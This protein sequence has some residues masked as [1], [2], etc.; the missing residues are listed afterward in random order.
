MTRRALAAALEEARRTGK[1]I[2]AAVGKRLFAPPPPS[3]HAE[4]AALF[5]HIRL[6]EAQYPILKDVYA[7]PNAEQSK[8]QA[9]KKWAEGMRPGPPDINVD[10]PN[11]PYHGLRIEFKRP[12]TAHRPSA[13]SPE[14]RDWIAR[15]HQGRDAARSSRRARSCRRPRRTHAA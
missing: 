5:K 10:V 8:A 14:Q 2:P 12:G 3:E 11:D 7:V 1:P 4:Q 15:L 13:L 6:L 9:G